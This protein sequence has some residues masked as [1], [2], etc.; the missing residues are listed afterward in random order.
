MKKV[1]AFLVISI[2][3]NAAFVAKDMKETEYDKLV[4]VAERQAVEI[5][6]IEQAAKLN[7]YKQAIIKAQE[8]DG[9]SP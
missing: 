3:G 6:I 5:A 9:K 1:I 2:I 8:S 7:Q 4:L